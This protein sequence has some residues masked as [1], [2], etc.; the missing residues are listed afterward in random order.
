MH[1]EIA[2]PELENIPPEEFFEHQ[3]NVDAVYKF[4]KMLI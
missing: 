2:S 4:Y 1:L 3:V